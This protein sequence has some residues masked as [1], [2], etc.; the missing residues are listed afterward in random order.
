ME[1]TKTMLENKREELLSRREELLAQA[2]A[3]NGALEN[4]E[5]WLTVLATEQS[6]PATEPDRAIT[7]LESG[8]VVSS[9]S[10]APSN[11]KLPFKIVSVE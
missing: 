2:N 8:S 11:T 7:S 9:S 1:I 10:P 4:I 6:M 5:F 3:C